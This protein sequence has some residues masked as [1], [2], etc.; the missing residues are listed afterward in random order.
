M[1]KVGLRMLG[2]FELTDREGAAV[3]LTSRKGRALLA[4]LALNPDRH[5]DRGDLAALLWGGR[6]EA[7]ARDSLNKCLQTLGKATGGHAAEIFET[8]RDSVTLRGE[9]IE[10]DVTRL[11]RLAESDDSEDLAEAGR[12]YGGELLAGF[13]TS[14]EPFEDWLR[15]EREAIRKTAIEVLSRLAQGWLGSGEANS[16]LAPAEKLVVL[17]PLNEQVHRLL[18]RAY[19]EAGRRSAALEQ[20]RA[21]KELLD[22]ELGVEPEAETTALLDEIRAQG[23]GEEL[24]EGI[25]Q[26]ATEP[27]RG[28]DEGGPEASPNEPDKPS[29]AV[30]A[31]DNMSGDEE[32][33]YFADGITEDLITELSRFPT[34]IVI[35]RHSSF[36]YKGQSFKIQ[37]VARDLGVRYIMEGSVRKAGNRVRINAQLIEAVNANHLWAER[38]DREMTD[39]FAVQDE[40]TQLIA[41]TLV[42]R[43]EQAHLVS[44]NRQPTKMLA[45]YD[46]VLRGAA[47]LT[48]YASGELDNACE[49]FEL[50]IER[51][52]NYARAHAGLALART[53]QWKFATE[54]TLAESAVDLLDDALASARRA[55]ALD[56]T[57]SSCHRTLGYVLLQRY[58]FEE[59]G[60]CFEKALALNPNEADTYILMGH[61]LAKTGGRHAQAL[62][63]IAKGMS[64]NPICPVWYLEV[65]GMAL[66][67]GEEYQRAAET[68]HRMKLPVYW[69]PLLLTA[70]YGQLGLPSEASRCLGEYTESRGAKAA[71]EGEPA[72]PQ[73]TIADVRRQSDWLTQ[74]REPADRERWVDGWR[75]AGMAE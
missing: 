39:I 30:L 19:D 3:A 27:S 70:C 60:S 4:Y 14:D 52:A 40:I 28:R 20:Y 21:C 2:D 57:D 9:A 75:K 46:Y 58:Q 31:F 61:F 16:A 74:Y 23:D 5:H 32:Q 42:G 38:Y 45:A 22:K 55:V 73:P 68:F 67:Q 59:A 50:A 35:A 44:A 34:L 47:Y 24:D 72:L 7:Q 41:A 37:D 18:M 10:V 64:L 54:W 66:Y 43:M 56:D 62:D 36:A 53:F 26:A 69:T 29:I 8:D 15:L 13:A 51:D 63:M 49:M 48:D 17:D 11:R 25:A 1:P 12:L 33:D 65:H 6:G 71:A